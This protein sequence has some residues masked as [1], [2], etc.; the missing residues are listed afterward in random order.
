MVGEENANFPSVQG[1]GKGRGCPGD[2]RDWEVDPS[3]L[4]LGK[5]LCQPLAGAPLIGSSASCFP[6][7]LQVFPQ[8]V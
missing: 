7:G 4:S 2:R 5:V 1:N 8:A 6:E 3:G